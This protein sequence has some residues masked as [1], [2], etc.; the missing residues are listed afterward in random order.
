MK[1]FAMDEHLY[2]MEFNAN[3]QIR[4]LHQPGRQLCRRKAL[5]EPSRDRHQ[6]VKES[7][8]CRLL[9]LAPCRTFAAE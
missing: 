7:P 9:R 2:G 4:Q 3:D 1:E 8:L 6:V 5:Q